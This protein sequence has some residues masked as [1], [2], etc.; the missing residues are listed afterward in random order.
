MLT[1]AHLPTPEALLLDY[2]RRLE[3]HREGRRVLW[4][5]LSRLGRRKRSE[6]DVRLVANLLRPVARRFQGDVFVL[7][8]GDVVV[9]LKDPEDAPIDAVLFDVRFSLAKDSLMERV[10]TEGPSAY[11]TVYEIAGSYASFAAAVM[12][13]CGRGAPPPDEP[14]D[15]EDNST[16]RLIMSSAELR[17]KPVTAL[18]GHVETSQGRIAIERLLERQTIARLEDARNLKR[19]GL[20]EHVRDL[21]LDVFEHLATAVSRQQMSRSAA[22]AEIERLLLPGWTDLLNAEGTGRHLLLFRMDTLISPEFLVF[23]RWLEQKRLERP[24]IGFLAPDILGDKRTADY[25]RGFLR[26]RGYRFG[27]A[28]LTLAELAA[29][30][31]AFSGMMFLEIAAGSEI[32]SEVAARLAHATAEL[33]EEAVLATGVA[34]PPELEAVFKAGIRLVSGPAVRV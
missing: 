3:R 20:R 5:H 19:W 22:F 14:R 11:L 9:C 30:G 13:A 15:E 32:S 33:G 8:T 28:G 4:L 24:A 25:L 17:A 7:A 23:D 31:G 10:E 2:A 29:A 21:A 27:L 6:A 1:K 16:A 12:R 26:E 34:T 18:P